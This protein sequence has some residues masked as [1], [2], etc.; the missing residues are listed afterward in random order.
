MQSA[1]SIDGFAMLATHAP[2]DIADLGERVREADRSQYGLYPVGGR[3]QI[4]LGNVPTKSGWAIDMRGLNQVVDFPA[5]D[6]TITV[7]SGITIDALDRIVAPENLRLP[8]DIPYAA[9]A[10]LGGSIAAN[11]SGS[12]RLGYGTLRDYVIGISAIN[13]EGREFKAGGRVVKNVAGYDINKLLVGSLGTLSIITQVTLK[14]KPRAEAQAMLFVGCDSAELESTLAKLHA[15]RTRPIAVDVLNRSAAAGT[16]A[17]RGIE[18]VA[19]PWTIVVAFDGNAEA[20]A[21]Q[22]KQVNQELGGR[23]P[24]V[25]E[26]AAVEPF[27]SLLADAPMDE[28][29]RLGFKASVL[30]GTIAT[31]LINMDGHAER[32]LLFAHAGNGI[33]RGMTSRS[34]TQDQAVQLIVAC[35]QQ[36]A[37]CN[38]AVIVTH[39]PAEWKARLEPWGPAPADAWLMREVKAKL[40]PRGMFNPGRFVAGI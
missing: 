4:G 16:L 19:A 5:R 30:P 29:A 11:V 1:D 6:M 23:S 27:W 2:R 8:I 17:P 13:D 28:S 12:R 3:T 36:A 32:P 39:A 7:Q 10:T 20:V 31:F 25:R 22:V 15:S 26:A 24:D 21:W 18:G 9:R 14:L 34:L 33:V 37:G 38:G 40:D 35:R